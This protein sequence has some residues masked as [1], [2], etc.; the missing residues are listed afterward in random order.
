MACEWI[1]LPGGGVAHLNIRGRRR[2]P[3][4]VCGLSSSRLCD[5]KVRNRK[6]GQKRTCD[7]PL[8]LTCTEP[9]GPDVDLCP[10]CAKETPQQLELAPP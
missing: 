5:G 9:R 2:P 1:R 6:L 10:T 8:C 4:S 3:C 7:A